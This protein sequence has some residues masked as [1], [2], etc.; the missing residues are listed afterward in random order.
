M[1]S[2]GHGLSYSEFDW[3]TEGYR[4]GINKYGENTV[5]VSVRVTNNGPYPGKDVVQLYYTQPFY[6]DSKYVIEKAL[7]NLGAYSKTSVL[8]PG[9]SEV[10][11]L[12]LNVRDMA[13]FSSLTGNYVLEGGKYVLEVASDASEARKLCFSPDNSVITLALASNEKCDL[14][15]GYGKLKNPLANASCIVY[16]PMEYGGGKKFA[17]M[18]TSDEVTGTKYRNLFSDCSGIREV[19]AIYLSRI[20]INGVPSVKPG[21]Y[22]RSPEADN[23]LSSAA[24]PGKKYKSY[25]DLTYWANDLND[26]KETL[27]E[28]KFLKLSAS[29]AQG[30]VYNSPAGKPDI[31]TIQEMFSD[32]DKGENEDACWN[33]F[34]DQ[35]SFYEML[36]VNDGCGFQFP[37]LE[38]YGV[39][40]SWGNDGAAQAGPLR[41]SMGRKNPV[42]DP[43][44]KVTGFPS[45]T[46][47]C[48]TW[49]PG[50]AYEM[51]IAQGYEAYFVG[52]SA[53]YAPGLNLHRNQSGGRNFEYMSEDTYLAGTIAAQLCNGMQNPGGLCAGVK[54]FMLNEQEVNRRGVHTYLSEQALRET[55]G[56]SWEICFKEGGAMG[57]MGAFNCLGYNWVGNSYA[58]NTALLRDEWGFKGYIVSDLG[59]IRNSKGGFYSWVSAIIAGE[60]S[61]EE[62]INW[63]REYVKEAMEYYERG[64]AM[65]NM[66][67]N[68]LRANTR[69]IF[70]AWSQSNGYIEDVETAIARTTQGKY[71]FDPLTPDEHHYTDIGWYGLVTMGEESNKDGKTRIPVRIS[72]NN[73]LTEAVFNLTTTS[74]LTAL[75]NT[76]NSFTEYHTAN[77]AVAGKYSYTVKFRTDK[78]LIADLE[79]FYLEFDGSVTTSFKDKNIELTFGSATDRTGH[80]TKLYIGERPL[81]P[82]PAQRQGFMP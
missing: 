74:P 59:A 38:Q 10:V 25:K 20:D 69:H 46:C 14:K 42:R 45:A 3:K 63:T 49:N 27:G 52:H 8:E 12:I 56:E 18:Y 47:L 1:Y 30:L 37:P 51:G 61:L 28:D 4:T 21:T 60:D 50:L 43:N 57:I 7:V 13:S 70:S 23:F 15:L 35:L 9:K 55:Y 34:L 66:L 24:G 78:A 54:H 64:G 68:S 44:F 72:G 79:L 62:T 81:P 31:Y 76:G 39:Y 80:A 40:W 16:K 48:A 53:L 32:I 82:P 36:H 29:V 11:K 65:A 22:P 73:G 5:E 71:N 17:V 26:L 2:F 33:R 67:L 41:I 75:G 6:N 19:N 77:E 58:L